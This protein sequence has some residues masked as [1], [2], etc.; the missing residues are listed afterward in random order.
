MKMTQ[1]YPESGKCRNTYFLQYKL[2]SV[3]PEPNANIFSRL[4]FWW[5]NPVLETGHR[6]PLAPSDLPSVWEE[7]EPMH[8]F[9]RLNRHWEEEKAKFT[10]GNEYSSVPRLTSTG[11]PYLKPFGACKE[12]W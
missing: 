10:Y 9:E 2:Y 3:P 7:D 1:R 12:G 11:L 4:T 8:T 6:R 5:L